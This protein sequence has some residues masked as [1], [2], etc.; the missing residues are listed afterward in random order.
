MHGLNPN[1][2]TSTGSLAPPDYDSALADSIGPEVKRFI[3]EKG[4]YSSEPL[5][6]K[7]IEY[8]IS[9]HNKTFSQNYILGSAHRVQETQPSETSASD[10]TRQKVLEKYPDMDSRIVSI[11]T[12]N[13][14]DF[15]GIF[16]ENRIFLRDIISTYIDQELIHVSK[17]QDRFKDF[18]HYI[19]TTNIRTN[20]DEL[21]SMDNPIYIKESLQSNFLHGAIQAK[22][23]ALLCGILDIR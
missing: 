19:S 14:S 20:F 17:K 6:K 4:G 10:I 9:H 3:E 8:L 1:P 16:R 5:G 13:R 2:T 15:D 23:C 18:E 21:R 7:I 11:L 12:A 22:V